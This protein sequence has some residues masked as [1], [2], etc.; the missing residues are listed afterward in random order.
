MQHDADFTVRFSDKCPG[1]IH[2][3]QLA[4]AVGEINIAHGDCQFTMQLNHLIADRARLP[5]LDGKALI[6]RITRITTDE[7]GKRAGLG[8]AEGLRLLTKMQLGRFS[9]TYRVG[10]P[11]RPAQDEPS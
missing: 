10:M 4:A 3:G 7:I 11:D 9:A 8:A 1:L 2:D 6:V 5:G